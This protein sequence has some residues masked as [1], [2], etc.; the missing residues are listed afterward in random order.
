M[1]K[2]EEKKLDRL[3]F[4]VVKLRSRLAKNSEVPVCEICGKPSNTLAPAHIHSRQFKI[5]R[6]ETDNILCACYYCHMRFMHSEPLGFAE[7]CR[8]NLDAWRLRR[9]GLMLYQENWN[10]DYNKI[11]K[12]LLREKQKLEAKIKKNNI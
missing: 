8:K 9:I 12:K 6:W 2:K 1:S 5:T 4:E 10:K 11:E 7:W 3:A